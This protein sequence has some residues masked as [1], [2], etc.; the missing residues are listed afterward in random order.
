MILLLV[1]SFFLIFLVLSFDDSEA[2]EGLLSQGECFAALQGMARGKAPGC[3]GH[4]M[5]FYLKFWDVLGNDLVLVFNSAFQFGSLSRSQ[6]R[7][8]I[9][10]AFKKGDRL[11][12]KNW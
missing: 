1:L 2:C 6:H 11:D 9:T 5:E 7:G 8:I 10:L 12:P 3:D 4:P